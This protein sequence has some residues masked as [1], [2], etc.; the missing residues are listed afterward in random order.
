M[1]RMNSRFKICTI[2]RAAIFVLATT[3]AA[4]MTN[5]SAARAQD[6]AQDAAQGAAAAPDPQ[7]APT[8]AAERIVKVDDFEGAAMNW[9]ALRWRQDADDFGPDM[10]AKV[11]VTDKANQVK[12]GKGSLY[13]IY[14]VVP[15]NVNVLATMRPLALEGMRSL[16]FRLKCDTASLI[17]LAL[18]E[19]GGARYQTTFYCPAGQWQQVAFDLSEFTLADDSPDPNGRLDL[20]QLQGMFLADVSGYLIEMLGGQQGA[21]V[22]WLDDFEYSSQPGAATATAGAAEDGSQAID[23]F[24]SGVFRWV[25]LLLDVTGG[26]LKAGLSDAPLSFGEGAPAK[27]QAD[28]AAGAVPAAG[29]PA[30]GGSKS[31]TTTYKREPGK[32]QGWLRSLLAGDLKTAASIS[33]ALKTSGDGLFLLSVTEKDNSRYQQLIEL[34]AADGWKKLS[35]ALSD[36][37]LADDST[38][39]NNALDTAQIKEISLA[40][41]SAM[42]PGGGQGDNTL[43]LDEVRFTAKK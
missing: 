35:Y 11:G 22:L 41:L 37:K 7:A 5:T 28:G 27:V 8:Q 33:L 3:L 31:L 32:I 6:A 12:T 2:C 34:K 40:D 17:A 42:L 13:Y 15:K 25:P 9:M 10:E 4:T 26:Q 23:S 18:R 21:R 14:N 19:E 20:D 30:A 24:D 29:V 39:E 16:R 38:D 36:F 43:W 1:K